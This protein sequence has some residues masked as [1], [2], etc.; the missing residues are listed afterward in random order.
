MTEL[1]RF[2]R[3]LIARYVA[4]IITLEALS[5]SLPDGWDLDAAEEPEVRRLVLLT[6]GYLADYQRDH[7]SESQ[8]RQLLSDE[9]SWHLKRSSDGVNPPA[10]RIDL[11]ETRVHAGADREPEAA[12]VS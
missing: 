5:H 12:L 4:G 8:L 2:V 7:L 1:E 11:V 10:H 6:V 3:D 9:A